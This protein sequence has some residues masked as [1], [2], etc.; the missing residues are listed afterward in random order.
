MNSSISIL[1]E[2]N[3]DTLIIV[4]VVIAASMAVVIGLAVYRGLFRLALP[5][6]ESRGQ[7]LLMR[8]SNSNPADAKIT[9]ESPKSA[10]ERQ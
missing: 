5:P 8:K 1:V 10:K 3:M 2:E 7:F 6:T 9:P 4:F